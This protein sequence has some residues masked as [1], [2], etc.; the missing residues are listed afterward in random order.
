MTFVDVAEIARDARH[1]M[2]IDAAPIGKAQDI[3]DYCGR[4]R[5]HV[6]GCKDPGDEIFEI[7]RAD[8]DAGGCQDG[9]LIVI[10]AIISARH[11]LA[12]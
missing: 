2:R 12:L 8:V 3:G 9:Y 1:A 11:A 6:F 7:A 4:I 5:P 10:E